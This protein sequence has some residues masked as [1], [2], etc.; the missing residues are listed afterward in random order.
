MKKTVQIVTIPLDKEG[1]SKGDLVD[2]GSLGY[3]LAPYDNK[4]GIDDWQAQQLLVLSDDEIQEGDKAKS[5]YLNNVT[6]II[7]E[8]WVDYKA[9]PKDVQDS[10]KKVIASYPRIPG[11]LPISKETVQAWIDSGTPEEGSVEMLY[12]CKNGDSLSGC[13]KQAHCGCSDNT[14]ADID[15]QGNLL[16]EFGKKVCSE[17]EILKKLRYA[18]TPE[19]KDS[20]LQELHD[21]REKQSKP[22]IPTDE[23]IE[24]KATDK[25]PIIEEVNY[26]N[27]IVIIEDSL[28]KERQGFVEG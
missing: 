11:T 7:N 15:P 17:K 8:E 21:I 3:S 4:A 18:E 25:Y 26:G 19:L 5:S 24:K 1:W 13:E 23:E 2:N 6:N 28:Y 10:F 20:F 22:A 27:V 12:W 14:E 9:A 16:L